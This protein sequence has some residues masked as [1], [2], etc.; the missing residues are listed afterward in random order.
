MMTISILVN[1]VR[2]TTPF[3]MWLF[4]FFIVALWLFVGFV[5][6][7]IGGWSTLA[8]YYRYDQPFSGEMIRAQS[9]VFGRCGYGSCINFGVNQ[10]GLFMVPILLFRTF[11]PPLFI[12]WNEISAEP[13]KR[14]FVFNAVRMRFERVPHVSLTI[15]RNLFDRLARSSDGRLQLAEKRF[16][17]V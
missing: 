17:S 8:E 9:A 7:R 2:D 15:Y 4:P 10:Q 16:I 14:L 1:A 6:S 13:Y 5:V 12:P 11:H 3:P